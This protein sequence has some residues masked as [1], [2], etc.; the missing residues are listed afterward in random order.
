VTQSSFQAGSFRD[1]VA[2]LMRP[3]DLSCLPDLATACQ[4]Q[5]ITTLTVCT[6]PAGLRLAPPGEAVRLV[7]ALL[8]LPRSLTSRAR[9]VGR[10]F[11]LPERLSRFGEEEDA[12]FDLRLAVDYAG[13]PSCLG[14]AVASA[15][16]VLLPYGHDLGNLL[17]WHFAG[18]TR[19]GVHWPDF[20]ATDLAELLYD[21][22]AGRVPSALL[23]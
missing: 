15:S 8:D 5:G 4:Q 16:L 3:E 9:L 19:V 6:L 12:C 18:A 13:S 2:A 23:R 21:M 7:D 10:R 22:P 11:Y 14:H 1:H 20:T 17:R